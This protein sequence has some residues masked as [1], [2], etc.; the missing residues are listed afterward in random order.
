MTGA[1]VADLRRGRLSPN[2]KNLGYTASDIPA[3]LQ[4]NSDKISSH[5]DSMVDGGGNGPLN[6]SM[7]KMRAR[8]MDPVSYAQSLSGQERADFVN[9]WGTA[10]QTSGQAPDYATAQGQARMELGLDVG[11]GRRGKGGKGGGDYGVAGEDAEQRAKVADEHAK[12]LAEQNDAL[13]VQIK[14]TH[15]LTLAMERLSRGA[16]DSAASLSALAETQAALRAGKIKPEDALDY[17]NKLKVQRNVAEAKK[18]KETPWKE[19]DRR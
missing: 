1:E 14:T 18:N 17:Y 4:L 2:L 10:L 7:R 6:E 3:L 19:R 8:G 15:I 13:K 11:G 12:N 16:D 9:Q 5:M